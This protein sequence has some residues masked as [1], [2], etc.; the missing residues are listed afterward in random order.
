MS[1]LSKLPA[2][3]ELCVDIPQWDGFDEAVSVFGDRL[4][5]LQAGDVPSLRH[6]RIDIG[7][8]GYVEEGQPRSYTCWIE[9]QCR[10]DEARE[11]LSEEGARVE[12]EL[13]ETDMWFDDNGVIGT[14]R[15][16]Y[17][18]TGVYEMMEDT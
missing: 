8:E 11:H 12:I 9:I 13:F 10:V 6:F 4:R 15:R 16:R 14:M 1:L 17:V 18:S 3:R 2:L 5:E 7:R